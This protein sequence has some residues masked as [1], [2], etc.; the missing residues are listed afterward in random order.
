M[1]FLSKGDSIMPLDD[2]YWHEKYTARQYANLD[3]SMFNA[4][5]NTRT[6]QEHIKYYETKLQE[7]IAEKFQPNI[8]HYDEYLR[9][10]KAAMNYV[11]VQ[12]VQENT[13]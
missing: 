11:E 10:F 12:E 13:K 5:R 1:A 9:A 8:A 7:A 3:A 4:G 6:L 2:R